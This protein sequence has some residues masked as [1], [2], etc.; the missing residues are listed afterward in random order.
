MSVSSQSVLISAVAAQRHPGLDAAKT[1]RPLADVPTISAIEAG[2]DWSLLEN[3]PLSPELVGLFCYE[4]KTPCATLFRRSTV[5]NGYY[6][7]RDAERAGALGRIAREL[8]LSLRQYGHDDEVA[9][10][11]RLVVSLSSVQGA[12]SVQKMSD[13]FQWDAKHWA[14]AI[15]GGIGVGTFVFGIFAP[16]GHDLYAAFLRPAVLSG[17]RKILEWGRDKNDPPPPAAGASAVAGAAGLGAVAVGLVPADLPDSG[18]GD[19]KAS[20]VS[21]SELIVAGKIAAVMAVAG[22]LQWVTAPVTAPA[23]VSATTLTRGAQ[24]LRTSF[25]LP[26]PAPIF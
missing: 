26:R 20:F 1:L 7:V 16:L 15:L 4:L 3:D 6:V 12:L 24:A 25:G 5:P 22:G 17:L 21:V 2:E 19:P 10:I 13:V 11:N 9:E 14:I 23:A 8:K 18:E